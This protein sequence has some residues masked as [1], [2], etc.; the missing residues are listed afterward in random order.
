M[1]NISTDSFYY[2]TLV[3]NLND[4]VHFSFARYGDGEW[5]CIFGKSGHHPC[6]RELS[7]KLLAVIKSRPKYRPGLQSLGYRQPTKQIDTTT[8]AYGLLRCDA[9]PDKATEKE[10]A[11]KKYWRNDQ[12]SHP[13][14]PGAQIV[15]IL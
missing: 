7:R 9:R 10:L 6:T 5:N 1:A 3:K 2:S 12:N 14:S 15:R 4:G 11:A 13:L 8:K